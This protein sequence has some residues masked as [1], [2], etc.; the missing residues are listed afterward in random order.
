MEEHSTDEEEFTD[1]QLRAALDRM[2][3]EAKRKAFAAGLPVVILKGSDL[4]ALHADGREEILER[5]ENHN[6]SLA[7]K[8]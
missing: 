2:G 1:E 7:A 8:K 4:I 6:T 3:N 5:L